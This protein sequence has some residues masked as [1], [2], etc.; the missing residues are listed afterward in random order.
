MDPAAVSVAKSKA[1]QLKARYREEAEHAHQRD[2]LDSTGEKH[3]KAILDGG[4]FK[5]LAVLAS[6]D[7]L[8]SGTFGAIQHHLAGV[9]TC[10]GSRRNR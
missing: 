9:R 8:P 3:K 10:L 1:E 4:T 7:L 6:L 2:R 5:D